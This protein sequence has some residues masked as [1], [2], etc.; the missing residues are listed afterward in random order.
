MPRCP[1]RPAAQPCLSR[2]H[3]PADMPAMFAVG[4]HPGC[5]AD[6]LLVAS[7]FTTCRILA[8]TAAGRGP[9]G[10][11]GAAAGAGQVVPHRRADQPAARS[12]HGGGAPPA[13]EHTARQE[14]GQGRWFAVGCW[15]GSG[16]LEQWKCIGTCLRPH[17]ASMAGL[18]RPCLS[19]SRRTFRRQ[20][21]SSSGHPTGG[22]TPTPMTCR[23]G[24]QRRHPVAAAWWCSARCVAHVACSV[25][26]YAG[27]RQS[28]LRP[29]SRP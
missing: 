19:P 28:M 11:A 4:A 16:A 6:M 25:L 27:G 24:W 29:C 26:C 5:L 22:G 17:E 13:G 10:P 23:C 18:K 9:V 20:A 8:T 21:A 14:G 7:S 15:L 3:A 1:E 12:S 2:A